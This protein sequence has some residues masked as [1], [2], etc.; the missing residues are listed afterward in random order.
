[1]IDWLCKLFCNHNDR[2]IEKFTSKLFGTYRT[3]YGVK[4]CFVLRCE[5]CT[6]I[7]RKMIAFS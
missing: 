2:I 7:K 4:H 3:I 1:M 6:R 5:K